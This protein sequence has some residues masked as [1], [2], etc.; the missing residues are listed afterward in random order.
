MIVTNTTYDNSVT[1]ARDHAEEKG[2]YFIQDT[3]LP[4]YTEIPLWIMQGYC[5]LAEEATIQL[6]NLEVRPTHV[7]LQCGVGSFTAAVAAFLYNKYE[8]NPPKIIVFEP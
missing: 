4:D 7:F 6:T 8:R 2:F 1:L 3:G 5:L